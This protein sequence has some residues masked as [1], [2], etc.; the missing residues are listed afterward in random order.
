[1][2]SPYGN[3][4]VEIDGANMDA[5]RKYWVEFYDFLLECTEDN[6]PVDNR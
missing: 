6:N 5:T 4:V 2:T 1:M 3:K